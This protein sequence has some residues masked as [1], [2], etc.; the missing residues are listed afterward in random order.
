V[1]RRLLPLVVVLIAGNLALFGTLRGREYALI[2]LE[3]DTDGRL[4]QAAPGPDRVTHAGG[5]DF[6]YNVAL[7]TQIQVPA[8]TG[9]DGGL[10]DVRSSIRWV[11]QLL[12]VG[13]DY[14]AE[15]WWLRDVVRAAQGSRR[16]MCDSYSRALVNACLR[17][18]YAA[19][20]VMLDGHIAA[21]VYLPQRHQWVFADALYDFIAT[22]SEGRPLSVV[23]CARRYHLGETVHWQ[24][25]TNARGDDDELGTK[26][27]FRLEE[28]MRQSNFA[29]YDGAFA[30][31][32]L[33]R[34]GRMRD[35]LL[36][37]VHAIQLALLGQPR[38][39]RDERA[40]RGLLGVWNGA[41][42]G[43]GILVL[44]Q[45]RLA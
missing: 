40:V 19:R 33:D 28:M 26:N 38:R 43:F 24:P 7:R 1:L 8:A 31:G 23:D 35:L 3:R 2:W 22:D 42:L 5:F 45:R 37:R 17:Q 27:L 20:I 16:F 36:H 11:R 44:A 18:G 21:E 25:V 6:D 15:N 39:D 14:H 12:A 41:M 13:E 34:L 4:F 9:G 30:F 32:R 10:D 29:I